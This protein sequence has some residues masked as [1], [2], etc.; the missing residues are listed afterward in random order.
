MQK[1]RRRRRSVVKLGCATEEMPTGRYMRTDEFKQ[2]SVPGVFAAGDAGRPFG[3]V[4]MA[5][6]DGAMAGTAGH[7]TLMF[8]AA[9]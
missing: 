3:S 5:V 6:A 1:A 2:T 9:A 7:R 8:Q 4:A